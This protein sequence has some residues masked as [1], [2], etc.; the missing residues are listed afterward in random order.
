M[1]SISVLVRLVN[2]IS[3]VD[4]NFLIFYT[5]KMMNSRYVF[6][7]SQLLVIKNQSVLNTTKTLTKEPIV[8]SS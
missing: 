1:Y 6:L 8:F 7:L 3:G 4:A 5:C 2:Y